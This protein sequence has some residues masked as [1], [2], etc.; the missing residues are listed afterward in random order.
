MS[1][2]E[3]AQ[4]LIYAAIAA[5]LLGLQGLATW[6]IQ[7]AVSTLV[8]P[9][10]FLAQCYTFASTLPSPFNTIGA[11]IITGV[12]MVFGISAFGIL[13]SIYGVVSN[14]VKN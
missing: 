2:E 12:L 7:Q 10:I 4:M 9:Y 11:L 8:E 5:A 6:L 1:D 3:K 13:A 14:A